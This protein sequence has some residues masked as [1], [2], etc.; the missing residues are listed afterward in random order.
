MHFPRSRLDR[1]PQVR[2]VLGAASIACSSTHTR[3][4]GSD[5]TDQCYYQAS[6]P[7]LRQRLRVTS[8][9]THSTHLIRQGYVVVPPIDE[10]FILQKGQLLQL[11][12][13]QL[14]PLSAQAAHIQLP[15]PCELT[16]RLQILR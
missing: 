12:Q 8:H 15:Q 7:A 14:E 11:C 2:I 13:L 3:Q 1:I 9:D 16:Y 4:A 6:F 10:A 5:S